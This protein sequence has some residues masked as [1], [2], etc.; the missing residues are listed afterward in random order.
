MTTVVAVTSGKAKAGQSLLSANLS[1]YLNHK[2]YRTGLMVAGARQPIWGVEPGNHWPEIMDGRLPLDKMIHRDVF[3]I[4]LTVTQNCGR[5]FQGLGVRDASSLDDAWD[6]L[7]TYAYLIIDLTAESSAAALACCLAATAT[8]LM[9]TPDTSTLVGTYEWLA[10]MARHDFQQPAV[11]VL[12]QVDNPVL[13]QSIYLRIRDLAQKRLNLKTNFWGSL[14]KEPQ[15]DS[16]AGRRFPLTQTM[17]QSELLR[18]IHAIGERL[19]AEHPPE[20]PTSTL[21]GFWRCFLER[22]EKIPDDPVPLDSKQPSVFTNMPP[23]E[24]SRHPAKATSRTL[25]ALN[26][27]LASISRDLQAIR[28]LLEIRAGR[29]PANWTPKKAAPSRQAS[30]DFDMFISQQQKR[31]ES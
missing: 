28:Q 31:E 6:K 26:T 2:G 1:Q 3:G 25:T 29:D 11:I 27:Q 30:L 13:A 7:D 20:N 21:K 8:I 19:V 24:K 5:T 14:N 18:S 10:L 4:D 12:D 22:L 15:L 16:R 17:P 9:M 23:M